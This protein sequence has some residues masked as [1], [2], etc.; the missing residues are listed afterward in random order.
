MTVNIKTT[1]LKE[2]V[3]AARENGCQYIRMD[4]LNKS[5]IEDFLADLAQDEEAEGFNDY[6]H[7]NCFIFRVSEIGANDAELYEVS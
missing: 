4:G 6:V 5:C 3:E 7:V 2:A 1:T